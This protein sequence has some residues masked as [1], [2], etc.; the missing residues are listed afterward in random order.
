[1][2]GCLPLMSRRKWSFRITRSLCVLKGGQKK[3]GGRILNQWNYSTVCAPGDS[4]FTEFV[5]PAD[6]GTSTIM[7]QKAPQILE[8]TGKIYRIIYTKKAPQKKTKTKKTKKTCLLCFVFCFFL[9]PR[10]ISDKSGKKRRKKNMC[11]C[12]FLFLLCVDFFVFFGCLFFGLFFV[13]FIFLPTR[14]NC[15]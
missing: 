13:F 12:L 2:Q 3:F 6:T 1:M 4:A 9:S 15:C 7:I 14:S 11:F 8:N 10:R 5:K